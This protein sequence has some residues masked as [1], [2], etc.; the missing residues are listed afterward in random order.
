M[1]LSPALSASLR[2]HDLK[3]ISRKR[4]T[5]PVELLNFAVG[6]IANYLQ[7]LEVEGEING[8][9]IREMNASVRLTAPRFSR[10]EDS[11]WR[12]DA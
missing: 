12:G 4:L 9:L 10:D 2:Q 7:Q 8:V 1:L 5:K 11:Q 6:T 3:A